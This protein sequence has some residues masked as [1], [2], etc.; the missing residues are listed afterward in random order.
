MVELASTATAVGKTGRSGGYLFS[1]GQQ[2]TN[3]TANCAHDALVALREVVSEFVVAGGRLH[4]SAIR[5]LANRSISRRK[6]A[7]AVD[8]WDVCRGVA[9][10]SGDR[11]VR[12][13]FL[14]KVGRSLRPII[15]DAILWCLKGRRERC[16]DLGLPLHRHCHVVRR[17]S[18]RTRLHGQM[19]IRSAQQQREDVHRETITHLMVQARDGERRDVVQ[20]RARQDAFHP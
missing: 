11:A 1:P 6:A 9:D 14:L 7:V 2:P 3:R 10:V 4:A 8:R 19:D 18:M 16:H 15:N 13:A 5:Q 12:R 17:S 20:P